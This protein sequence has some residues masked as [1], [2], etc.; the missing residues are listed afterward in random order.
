MQTVLWDQV[1][2]RQAFSAA[3]AAQ[4]RADIEAVA[5]MLARAAGS[6]EGLGAD[7]RAVGSAVGLG[8]VVEGVVLLG[9]PAVRSGGDGGG[10]GEGEEGVGLDDVI[11]DGNEH[12]NHKSPSNPNAQPRNPNVN[13]SDTNDTSASLHDGNTSVSEPVLTLGAVEQRLFADNES[14]REV[15]DALGLEILSEADARA[16]LARRVEL[17]V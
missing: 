14:A 8:R 5:L 16:V 15:L 2:L 11:T 1:L 6:A 17:A 3:G 9:V 4:L 12:D 7:L 13:L 10:E